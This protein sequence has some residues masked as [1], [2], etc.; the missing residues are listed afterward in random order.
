MIGHSLGGLL[1]ESVAVDYLQRRAMSPQAR[2]PVLAALVVVASPRAGSGWAVRPLEWLIPEAKVLRRLAPRSATV[3]E[4]FTTYVERHNLASGAAGV[5]VLPVYA[6]LGGGDKIV[7][8]FSAA[9]GVP[10][11]QRLYLDADHSSIVKPDS[12]DKQLLG[13]L[14]GLF[15]ARLEVRA[16]AAREQQHFAHRTAPTAADP[17]PT[18]VTRFLSDTSGLRWEELYNEARHAATTT[19]V[20]VHDARD[21]SG[22]EFDL[23]IAVHDADLVVAANPAVRAIVLEARRERDRRSSISVGI[24]PVGA[25]FR[26]AEAT[27][28]EW[29]AECAPTTS[30]YVNGAADAAGLRGVL[31]T[32][33]QLVIGRDPRRAV[34]A[35]LADQRFEE[36][37]D[38]YDDPK[39]GGY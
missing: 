21:V 5:V 9:F 24:C 17:R 31:A 23:L 6:A 12:Q 39:G 38:V 3:D 7:G 11:T 34:R 28:G 25:N 26:A 19:A 15:I 32:L 2:P 18:V 4:F 20:A 36:F 8:Q 10:T 1:V 33:F 30:V 14:H 35:A 29:L 27:V 13:W 22:A 16:Q 37:N